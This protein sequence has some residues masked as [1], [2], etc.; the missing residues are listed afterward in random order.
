MQQSLKNQRGNLTMMVLAGGVI[1]MIVV[2]VI[3]FKI[4]NS[5]KMAPKMPSSES[6]DMTRNNPTPTYTS[7]SQ[8][9]KAMTNTTSTDTQLDTDIKSLDQQM[10]KMDTEVGQSQTVQTEPVMN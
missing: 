10:G 1:L 5:R 4:R 7:A 6:Q 8:S 2:G 9:P 3:A